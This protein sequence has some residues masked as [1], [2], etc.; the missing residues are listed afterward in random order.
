[1]YGQ[2][3][4]SKQDLSRSEFCVNSIF[5][6]IQGE[7][8]DVGRPA[9]FLRMAGCNLRCSFCDTDFTTKGEIGLDALLEQ[10]TS[11]RPDLVCITGG[12]PLLQ[13]IL[14]IVSHLNC[15]DIVVSVETAGTVFLPGMEN[16]FAPDRSIHGNLVVCSPKTPRVAEPLIP[17]IGAYKY[18]VREH[19]NAWA[20]GLPVL[21]YQ[22]S[23]QGDPCRIFRPPDNKVPVYLQPIDDGDPL[24]NKRNQDHVV[25]MCKKFGY[26]LSLQTHKILGVE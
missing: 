22:S 7:G 2:N 13:N 17:C 25:K 20:D 8:P 15:L 6:T 10:I 9:L 12:E 16:Y 26:R 11:Y 23:N 19:G 14:P 24:K 21:S 4:V 18:V 1:M 3:A 5:Y